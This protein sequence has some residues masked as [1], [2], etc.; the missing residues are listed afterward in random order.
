MGLN[1]AVIIFPSAFGNANSAEITHLPFDLYWIESF[2]QYM[3]SHALDISDIALYCV[4]LNSCRSYQPCFYLYVWEPS[5]FY[6][7][8]AD[9]GWTLTLN[10]RA[11]GCQASCPTVITMPT[12][13][14]RPPWLGLCASANYEDKLPLVCAVMVHNHRHP[15]TS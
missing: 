2:L 6:S 7:V 14:S 9:F 8:K 15:M 4:A 1:V 13:P 10:W 5:I 3:N 12:S 11:P